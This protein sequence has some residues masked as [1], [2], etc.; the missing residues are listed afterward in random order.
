MRDVFDHSARM[1]QTPGT[2]TSDAAT[3]LQP[4]DAAVDQL[5]G[6]ARPATLEEAR[7]VQLAAADVT[8]DVP[9]MEVVGDSA[10]EK[11]NAAL[12][13]AAKLIYDKMHPGILGSYDPQGVAAILEPMSAADRKKVEELYLSVEANSGKTPLRGDLRNL[14][15][16][17]H[18]TLEGILDREDGKPNTAGNVMV[19]LETARAEGAGLIW[20]SD[21]AKGNALLRAALSTLNADSYRQLETT[22]QTRYGTSLESAV[23]QTPGISDA[24]KRLLH[25]WQK[26]SDGRTATDISEMARLA[27]ASKNL[28]MLASVVQGTGDAF[29]AARTELQNDRSF[30]QQIDNNWGARPARGVRPQET[31]EQKVAHDLVRE[32]HISLATIVTGNRDV[33]AGFLDNEVGTEQA[34]QSATAQERKLF[35]DG[36]AA[37]DL[38]AANPNAQLTPEQQAGKPYYDTINAALS[39]FNPRERE[40]LMDQLAEGRKT[41]ISN[42]AG[43]HSEA[44]MQW[45]FG[46]FGGGHTTENLMSQVERMPA[47]DHALLSNPATRDAYRTRLE[48]SLETYEPDKAVRDRIMALVDAKTAPRP[49]ADGRPVAPT[50]EEAQKIRRSLGEVVADN[51]ESSAQSR[52]SVAE[53]VLT[54]TPADAQKYKDDAAFRASVDRSLQTTSSMSPADDAAIYL[55][56]SLLRQVA[57]TGQP[58]QLGPLEQFS[59]SMMRETGDN[60]SRITEAQK[61]LASS[62]SLRDHMKTLL[63]PLTEEGGGGAAAFDKFSAE[64]KALYRMFV[65]TFGG[66]QGQ[67]ALRDAVNGVQNAHYDNMR[68]GA[69]ATTR[70]ALY[71]TYDQIAA[72][73]EDQRRIRMDM[74]TADQRKIA[75]E[76]IAQGGKPTLADRIRSFVIQDGG[77]H[78]DFGA[79]LAKLAQDPVAL[80]A[81]HTEY[82]GK[83]GNLSEQ[84]MARVPTSD[85]VQYKG[86]LGEQTAQQQFFDRTGQ[87]SDTGGFALDASGLALDRT[88]GI[89][90]A[91]IAEYEA[92]RQKLPPEVQA[93]ISQQFSD[94]LRNHQESKERLADAAADALFLTAAAV[95][96]IATWGMDAP[97]VA[98]LI[99]RLAIAGGTARP[100]IQAA[101]RGGDLEGSDIFKQT[102]RGTIEGASLGIVLPGGV[103]A[104]GVNALDQ[105]VVAAAERNGARVLEGEILPP[106]RATT[107]RPVAELESPVIDL[108]ATHVDDAATAAGTTARPSF[109]ASQEVDEVAP[110]VAAERTTAEIVQPLEI[111]DANV[112]VASQAVTS[113]DVVVSN[114][115]LTEVVEPITDAQ[116]VVATQVLP[117][118][119]NVVASRVLPEI[120]E[121]ISDAQVVAAT[122]VAP[123]AE[124]VVANRVLSDVVEPITDAQVVAATRVAPD[125]EVVV[126]NRV[127]PEVV[128]PIRNTEAVVLNAAPDVNLVEADAAIT[129]VQPITR[130]EAVVAREITPEVVADVPLIVPNRFVTQAVPDTAEQVALS[131]TETVLATNTDNVVA[132]RADSLVTRNEVVVP[133]EPEN[134]VVAQ[135]DSLVQRGEV[136]VPIE[137]E[138]VV[139]ANRVTTQAAEDVPLTAVV[140]ADNAVVANTHNAV[141]ANTDN[142]VVAN[143]DNAV[144]ANA[145]NAVETAV[146]PR[147]ESVIASTGDNAITPT[148][149][150]TREGFDRLWARMAQA[151]STTDDL[152]RAAVPA[153]TNAAGQVVARGT[154]MA[155]ELEELRRLSEQQRSTAQ[156][157]P[158]AQVVAEPAREQEQPLEPLPAVPVEPV[159]VQ[160]L[161]PI[162]KPSDLLIQLATVKN[163]E[164]PY[165]SAARIL[166]EALGKPADHK[167]VM[168]LTRAIQRVFTAENNGNGDMSGLRVRTQFVTPQNFS[169]LLAEVK[170]EETRKMLQAKFTA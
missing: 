78:T 58:P 5:Q 49:G 139:V 7:S 24:D 108:T 101:I 89:N 54:M 151:A 148:A 134:V 23:Q 42:L 35:T 64:D 107:V 38:L 165:Q 85:T 37:A 25:F 103:A 98:A 145:E 8:A 69:S 59:Q 12:G 163:G 75:D 43:Q 13:D 131:N 2:D 4:D 137:P 96:I 10:A 147:V 81:L 126:A 76:V 11:H 120:A 1:T 21:S 128:E 130:T 41:L 30:Q 45:L 29:T 55:S 73:P 6:D 133:I 72:L 109:R 15:A 104:K 33:L 97:A 144:V 31:T 82:S 62:P 138:N 67:M 159:E 166:R 114:R 149:S 141:V 115:A 46:G 44:S 129:V 32:G 100:T 9:P 71:G 152:A 156:V 86:L 161:P 83:Y 39:K 113:A 63:R 66:M 17:D 150:A 167:E 65:G 105:P 127:L 162:P 136:V 50:F 28:P 135:R 121:P 164:G 57:E 48:K 68:Y 27:V 47:Q 88:L 142:A 118:A 116:A 102:L 124:V 34:L 93:A 40:I 157:V 169:M 94:S 53:A 16:V 79:E 19:A 158:Q 170:D 132:A 36:R 22:F 92:L 20:N 70:M 91:K 52:R 18:R 90:Q 140:N 56:S 3:K 160:E 84:F 26:G 95:S 14:G 155:A 168:A 143:A 117:D 74:M 122:R 153:I 146:V 110:L 119:Q 77:K 123:D 106:V 51:P 61:I 154:V 112:V 60:N 80:R 125:A 87:V 99:P 111:T